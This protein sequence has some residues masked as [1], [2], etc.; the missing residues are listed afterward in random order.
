MKCKFIKLNEE[1][2]KANSTRDSDYCFSHNPTYKEQKKL[3]VIKG[4]LSPKKTL[5][6][7]DEELLL[8]NANDAKLF[9]SK[10]INGVWNGTIPATP[11]ANTLGF[12]I[13]CFLDAYEKSDLET[14]LEELEKQ[15]EKK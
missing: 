12:L 11:V 14:R 15:I 4:G 8:N 9:L 10:V 1:Q 5:L 6:S 2:C 7:M 13:R 3:A